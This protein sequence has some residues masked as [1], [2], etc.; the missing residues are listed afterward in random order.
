MGTGKTTLAGALAP[1]L[2]ANLLLEETAR[3]P[4]IADF[5]S[6]PEAYAIETEINFVLLHYH[7]LIRGQRKG[8]FSH[9]V[10]ADFAIDRDLVFATLTIKSTED[11]A[12]FDHVYYALATRL[13][14]PTVL[15]YLQAP[16]EFLSARISRR[17]REYES[18]ISRSYLEAVK[19]ALDEYFIHHYEGPKLILQ[20]PDL[21][22]S[23]D[24]HYSQTVA[25]KLSQLDV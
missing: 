20:A 22:A 2:G 10:L 21:D 17:G 24:P 7:Q 19:R 4:F 8:L 3:H 12:I 6:A 5:Y 14:R 1:L 18:T 13:P 16:I 11:R 9:P 23:V 25:S 15:L